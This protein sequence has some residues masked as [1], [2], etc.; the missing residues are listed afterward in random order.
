MDELLK[1]L[2]LNSPMGGDSMTN[3]LRMFGEKQE[4]TPVADPEFANPITPQPI[5][6]VSTGTMLDSMVSPSGIQ[7]PLYNYNQTP[8]ENIDLGS[9]MSGD[10]KSGFNLPPKIPNL[11]MI[12][13]GTSANNAINAIGNAPTPRLSPSPITPP[14]IK[15]K[16]ITEMVADMKQQEAPIIQK[17]EDPLALLKQ[18]QDE[19]R[20]DL[21]N[22]NILDAA[23]RIGTAI[24]GRG[25]LEYKPGQFEGLKA[26]AGSKV[27]DY[28]EQQKAQKELFDLDKAKTQIDDEKAKRDPNSDLS[29]V[30][31]ASVIDS[32]NRIGRKDL[33]GMV[34]PNM[35]SKQVEDIFGQNN[36]QNMVTAFE[37][38]QNR[39]ELAK[40][41]AGEKLAA[42]REKLDAQDIKR[43]DSANKVITASLGRTNT[44]FGR[45]ANILRSAEA[46]EQLAHGTTNLDSRQIKEVAASLDSMLTM[47]ASTVSG[48]A[49]LV[50]H[51]YAGDMAKIAEYITNVP[52][53]TQQ[54]A[55]IKKMLDTV[56][57]EKKLAEEQIK[58][59]SKKML[60]SYADLQ[61]KQPEAWNTMIQAQGLDPE[62]FT[63][64]D[65]PDKQDTKSK[66]VKMKDP[67]GNI[68]EIPANQ[69][70]AAKAAGGV[71]I[72]E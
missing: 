3:L 19:K 8:Q 39:L 60:S 28:F 41:K 17:Q 13:A 68:R 45:M 54:Q 72:N 7:A 20:D 21:R 30:G 49:G 26:A 61:K 23:S 12:N 46:I 37:A 18:L 43:L 57:R 42:N 9:A 4:Q 62:M 5:S 16:S 14:D 33:A 58:R 22:V 38:Q 64:L 29:K 47:G 11:D 69:V 51:S 31:R 44:A 67:T 15:G 40:L 71:V 59:E 63:N 1:S 24:A 52:K 48:R 25:G 2:R 53:G 34:T 70:D 36:L 10:A 6:P 27:S 65:K 56:T 35:S 50:P 32:L 55:F 66:T